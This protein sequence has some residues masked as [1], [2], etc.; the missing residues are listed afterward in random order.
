MQLRPGGRA[1]LLS[2]G[3]SGSGLDA[4]SWRAMRGV[5]SATGLLSA[6]AAP[7]VPHAHGPSTPPGAPLHQKQRGS[8]MLCCGRPRQALVAC[9]SSRS[10]LPVTK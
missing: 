7:W 9:M 8:G 2:G 6:H 5:S 3:D 1:P 10:S 4:D